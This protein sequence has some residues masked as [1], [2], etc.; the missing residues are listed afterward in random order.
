MCA[1]TERSPWAGPSSISVRTDGARRKEKKWRSCACDTL[2]KSNMATGNPLWMEVFN[3]NIS[4]RRPIFQQAMCDYQRV[5][6]RQ[7]H[8]HQARWGNSCNRFTV[9]MFYI[10]HGLQLRQSCTGRGGEVAFGP[11][12]KWPCAWHRLLGSRRSP[13]LP[14]N[15]TWYLDVHGSMTHRALKGGNRHSK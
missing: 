10:R 13:K 4:D 5:N 3:R 8:Y 9:P 1:Q 15:K 11:S 6:C 7:H 12:Q 2:W 14:G